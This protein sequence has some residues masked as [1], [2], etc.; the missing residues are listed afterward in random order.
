MYELINVSSSC[1]YIEA[2]A[3]IGLIKTAENSVI[4][5]DSGND[6]DAAKKALRH[7][8]ANGWSLQAVYNTH[9]N[10]DHIGGNK[11]LSSQTG[12]KIYAPEIERDFTKNP[13][14]EPAFLYGGFPPSELK[15][16]FLLAPESDALP[17]TQDTLPCGIETIELPGHFF[18][19]VGFYSNEEIAYLADCL[20][21]KETLQKY[22]IGFIYDVEQY[23]NTLEKVKTLK[24]KLFIPSHAPAT[25]DI[26]DLVDYNIDA[27]NQ[28]SQKITDIC[29][30][31]ITFEAVLKRLFDDFA[32]TMNFQQY[33]LVGST[34]RSYLSYLKNRGAISAFFE[35]NNLYWEKI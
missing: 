10:A 5:I 4:L 28:I 14:L 20:S 17:L 13:I 19:M 26:T 15:N 21:S 24:A 30:T 3:K 1:Y 16:K 33:A 22:R 18:N 31:P 25:D 29:D 32:L 8:D 34:V 9:S 11:Y 27:V 6:K 35:N 2:P 12:C 7:I 23:L